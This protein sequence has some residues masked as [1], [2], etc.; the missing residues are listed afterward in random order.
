MIKHVQFVVSYLCLKSTINAF[1]PRN[2]G[3]NPTRKKYTLIGKLGEIETW[4]ENERGGKNMQSKKKL[5]TLI[6]IENVQDYLG[7]DILTK[8]P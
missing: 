5:K 7:L 6:G 1:V 8:M 2:V 3:E 4:S